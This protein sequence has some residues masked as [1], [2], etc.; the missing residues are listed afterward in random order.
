MTN[1]RPRSCGCS[2]LL[3]LLFVLAV[4]VAS[5]AVALAQQTKSNEELL[6]L[7]GEAGSSGGRMVVSLRAEPKTLN[8]VVATDAPSQEVI[9]TMQAD[10]VHI[11]RSTHLTEPALAKS[12]KISS[13][14]LD[15]TLTLRLGF[16]FYD[17]GPLASVA[18]K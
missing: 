17:S 12:W 7:S 11:N 1:L 16:C 6:A 2:Q 15:Y 10:L 14:G 4:I 13:D 18:L 8:P 3:G 9:G 5:V